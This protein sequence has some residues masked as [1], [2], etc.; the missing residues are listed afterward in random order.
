MSSANFSE[1]PTIKLEES[2]EDVTE[3][4]S[5]LAGFQKEIGDAAVQQSSAPDDEDIDL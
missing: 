2:T 5:Y 3:I 1:A 4:Q